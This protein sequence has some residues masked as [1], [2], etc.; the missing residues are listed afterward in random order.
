MHTSSNCPECSSPDAF[1]VVWPAVR[2]LRCDCGYIASESDLDPG[3]PL[4]VDPPPRSVG[5]LG[6]IERWQKIAEE[7]RVYADNTRNSNARD[8]LQRIAQQYDQL[9]E[10]AQ[11]R[12]R[13]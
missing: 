4:L 8:T 12:L 3:N 10:S 13:N 9:A 2:C 5:E 7:I 11:R 1:V 6:K